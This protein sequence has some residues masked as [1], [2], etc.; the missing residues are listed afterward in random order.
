MKRALITIFAVL[1]ADQLLKFYIKTHMYLG[2]EIPV[3]NW[4]IIHFTENNGMAFGM[5]LEGQYGKLLLSLFRIL[6]VSGIGWYL[7]DISRKNAPKGLVISVALIFAGALGNIIDSAF[8]GLLFSESSYMTAQFMPADGGYAGFLHG[9]VVDMLYFPL[10]EGHFPDWFPVWPGEHFIFFR[11]V[12]NLAD[13]A[14]TIGVLLILLFQK[15]FFPANENTT[16]LK[17]TEPNIMNGET[18]S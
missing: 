6:A 12:F 5:E 3:T 14:I 16:E 4:F 1:L 13:S 8:Y 9:K 11:P 17:E 2:E 15:K 18:S 10:I 7:F